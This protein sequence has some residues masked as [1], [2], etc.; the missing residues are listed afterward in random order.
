MQTRPTQHQVLQRQQ[1]GDRARRPPA[2]PQHQNQHVR[3]RRSGGGA[4]SHRLRH[5]PRAQQ[6]V[7]LLLR[8]Q[9]DQGARQ[10]EAP[11]GQVPQDQ[12]SGYLY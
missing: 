7:P 1:P 3:L 9:P 4:R 8:L 10:V 6:K 11:A 5:R 12:K 2:A